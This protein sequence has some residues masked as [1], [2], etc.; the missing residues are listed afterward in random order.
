MLVISALPYRVEALELDDGDDLDAI[1][2]SYAR[3]RE[4]MLQRITRTQLNFKLT[5]SK[6]GVGKGNSIKFEIEFTLQLM[7]HDCFK[8]NPIKVP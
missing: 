2:F 3:R 5:Q 7:G 1:C 8:R 6:L 4:Q